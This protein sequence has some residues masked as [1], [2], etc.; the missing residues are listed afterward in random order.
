MADSDE[1]SSWNDSES[2]KPSV[3]AASVTVFSS[4]SSSWDKC[5]VCLEK[6]KLKS[7]KLKVWTQHSW[8][9]LVQSAKTRQDYLW[10]FL[11]QE[12]VTGEE[13]PPSGFVHFAC[14][15]KYTHKKSLERANVASNVGDE[16]SDD[17]PD[18]N[19]SAHPPAKRVRTRS[20]VPSTISSLCLFC[21][22]Q[23]LRRRGKP[24]QHLT[25]TE[26]F[27]AAEKIKHAAHIREDERVS[28]A[29]DGVDC[30]AA[31]VKYHKVCYSKYIAVTYE[32]RI[33]SNKPVHHNQ[34][35]TAVCQ[36]IQQELLQQ[37]GAM[38]SITMDALRKLYCVQLTELRMDASTCRNWVLKQRIKQHFGE[39]LRFVRSSVSEPE[40][41]VAATL[42]E[43]AFAM[44]MSQAITNATEADGDDDDEEDMCVADSSSVFHDQL[45]ID[46]YHAALRLHK[47][48][49][50]V[51]PVLPTPPHASDLTKEVAD[52]TVPDHLYN[53]L[54]GVI[55]G[56]DICQP[57]MTEGRVP[58]TN[59]LDTVISSIG[60]DLVY[61][62]SH[63]RVIPPKHVAL[64]MSVRHLTRSQQL[65]TT[66]NR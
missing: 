9:R 28:M 29:V 46:M 16:S 18:D 12:D 58:L 48:I 35:F 3:A 38:R 52:R 2:D 60:Q 53:F 50:A 42:P 23:Y 24:V 10:H 63:G 5:L 4:S 43:S 44:L 64:A 49:K 45:T 66:L 25:Q 55:G 1:D 6:T 40:H 51:K 65:I 21:Q 20:A 59:Q 34:A 17:E 37:A 41:V 57:I 56:P 30:I 47:C 39:E 13:H 27:E 15:N 54:A 36:C 31:E 7:K 22:H 33:P 32:Q 11:V 61:A 26:T 8:S 19:E 14:Y 62:A